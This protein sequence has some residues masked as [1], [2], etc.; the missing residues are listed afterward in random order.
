MI[1]KLDMANAFDRVYHEFIF[2]VMKKWALTQNLYNWW[3]STLSL[4]GF[5]P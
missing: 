2:K 5:I 3:H 4:L 1:V